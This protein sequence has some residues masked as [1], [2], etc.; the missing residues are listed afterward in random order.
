M[1]SEDLLRYLK[2]TLRIHS[3]VDDEQHYTCNNSE[4]KTSYELDEGTNYDATAPAARDSYL[5]PF[6]AILGLG[7]ALTQ[8]ERAILRG[9]KDGKKLKHIA[10]E[11]K[12]V[13][14][15]ISGSLSRIKS[16]LLDF[17]DDANFL[18]SIGVIKSKKDGIELVTS[19]L[20][21]LRNRG[22]Y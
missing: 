1:L 21:T 22:R 20:K 5:P 2:F 10:Y 15:S 18:L 17:L 12:T 19:N 11:N 9:L 14:T 4:W 6:A 16:K 8:R 13:P 3:M 7:M